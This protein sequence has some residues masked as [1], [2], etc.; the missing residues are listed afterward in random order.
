M[1]EKGCFLVKLVAALLAVASAGVH[2]VV[3]KVCFLAELVDALLAVAVAVV[4]LVVEKVS[5][6][7]YL[8]LIVSNFVWKMF[9]GWIGATMGLGVG[10]GEDDLDGRQ[11]KC[12][13]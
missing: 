10:T 8:I 7:T 1:V 2:L 9:E 3:E 4:H 13:W 5:Y 12:W 6:L 11:R